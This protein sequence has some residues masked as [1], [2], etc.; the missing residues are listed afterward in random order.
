MNLRYPIKTLNS[1]IWYDEFLLFLHMLYIPGLL[2]HYWLAKTAYRVHSP[3]ISSYI[4][5]VLEDKRQFYALELLKKL[6]RSNSLYYSKGNNII[7]VSTAKFPSNLRQFESLFRFS[8]WYQGDT[9]IEIGSQTPMSGLYL[10]Q[11]NLNAAYRTVLNT[12]ELDDD[13]LYLLISEYK[14]PNMQLQVYEQKRPKTLIVVH[15]AI[16]QKLST[17]HITEVLNIHTKRSYSIIVMDIYR[18]KRNYELWESI[19]S[20]FPYS[21]ALESNKMGISIFDQNQP[22]SIN[23]HVIDRQLKPYQLY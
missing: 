12:T 5:H 7:E 20:G 10:W 15:P 6:T 11:S 23:M 18:C 16:H 9:I 13:E 1:K 3:L 17:G 8:Q 21:F 19:K 4:E 2:R 22:C 14:S